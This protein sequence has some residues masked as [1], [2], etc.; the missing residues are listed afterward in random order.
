MLN[1]IVP[2]SRQVLHFSWPEIEEALLGLRQLLAPPFPLALATQ[3]S[4]VT[5]SGRYGV[6]IYDSLVIASAVEA[7]S[8]TFYSEDMH[9]G[10]SIE[11][12][13]TIHNPFA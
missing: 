1:E 12:L 2:V 10:Q 8:S 13:I 7:W 9:H 3:E 4:A 6:R 11:G 5:I